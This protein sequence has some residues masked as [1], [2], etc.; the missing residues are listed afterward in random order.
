[1]LFYMLVSAIFHPATHETPAILTIRYAALSSWVPYITRIH[2]VTRISMPAIEYIRRNTDTTLLH[3]PPLNA[4]LACTTCRT[5]RSALA[6]TASCATATARQSNHGVP[7]ARH[8][9]PPSYCGNWAN[10]WY[11]TL[12]TSP[13]WTFSYAKSRASTCWPRCDSAFLA[14]A[15]HPYSTV[16]MHTSVTTRCH[17]PHLRNA[18]ST[19]VIALHPHYHQHTSC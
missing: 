18:C 10:A 4:Y 13:T 3:P 7:H 5:C 6:S 8:M 1:M 19:P 16:P 12:T 15:H 9:S 11:N 2:H 14:S 17:Q